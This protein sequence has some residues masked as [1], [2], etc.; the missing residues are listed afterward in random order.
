VLAKQKDPAKSGF[1][2]RWDFADLKTS[3]PG[4]VKAVI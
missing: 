3:S 2:V 4:F 1:K